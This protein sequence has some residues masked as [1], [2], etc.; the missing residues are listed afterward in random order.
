[1][2]TSTSYVDSGLT[3]GTRYE[4]QIRA[5]NSVAAAAWSNTAVGEIAPPGT[6]EAVT[7]PAVATSTASTV[8]L[9]WTTPDDSGSPLTG[10]ELRRME[11]GGRWEEVPAA[12]PGSATMY[13][14]TTALPGTNYM[15]QIRA[16]NAVSA[17]AF[18]Q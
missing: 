1:M 16:V 10:Y 13:T 18:G 5:S 2:V 14:D 3:A 12:I 17:G 8:S 7:D 4:Y 6:P 11:T 15:Y 9:M